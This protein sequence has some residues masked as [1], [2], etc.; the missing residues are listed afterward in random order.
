[1][2]QILKFTAGNPWREHLHDILMSKPQG[3]LE[4]K[5]PRLI[6]DIDDVVFVN[7]NMLFDSANSLHDTKQSPKLSDQFFLGNTPMLT[8]IN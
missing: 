4:Q 6:P 8:N 5:R 2:N 3:K 1:M 7:L